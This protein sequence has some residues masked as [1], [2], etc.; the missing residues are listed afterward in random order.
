VSDARD[1]LDLQCAVLTKGD[2]EWR[3]WLAYCGYTSS[4]VFIWEADDGTPYTLSLKD[5]TDDGWK[6]E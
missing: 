1:T 2:S 5:L 3:G 6:V 4:Q